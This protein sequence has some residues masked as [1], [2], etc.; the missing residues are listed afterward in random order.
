VLDGGL[1]DP[2]LNGGERGESDCNCKSFSRVFPIITR[3]LC[4]K[5]LVYGVLCVN[6]KATADNQ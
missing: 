3:D 5:V 2:R 1:A 4:V 6:C